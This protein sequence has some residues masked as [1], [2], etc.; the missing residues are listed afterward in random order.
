M[1]G[2]HPAVAQCLHF[3]FF[4]RQRTDVGIIRCTMPVASHDAMRSLKSDG[5]CR[6]MQKV[7]ERFGACAEMLEMVR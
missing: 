6:E 5:D 3:P 4:F 7:V 1:V 2:C